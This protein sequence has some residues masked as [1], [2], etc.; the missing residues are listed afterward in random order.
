M[1]NPAFTYGKMKNI[2]KKFLHP[3]KWQVLSGMKISYEAF[4]IISVTDRGF[5]SIR[6]FTYC[7]MTTTTA[8]FEHLMFD[9]FYFY[10]RDI[11][12]LT[13]SCIFGC[14]IIECSSTNITI[15]WN[16]FL[17]LIR[18]FYHL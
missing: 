15:T 16:M 6:I 1:M 8:F 10:F 13:F 17:C 3:F 5:Y 12:H 9:N 14:Y 2:I 11:K 7:F 4:N 18:G